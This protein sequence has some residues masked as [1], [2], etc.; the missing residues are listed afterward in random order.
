MA[1]GTFRLAND[2]NDPIY[3]GGYIV[4]SHNR[5]HLTTLPPWVVLHIPHDSTFIPASIRDQFTLSDTE[6][7]DEILKIHSLWWR[8]CIDLCIASGLCQFGVL[9]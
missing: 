5:P 9:F 6:L 7:D 1:K 8:H 2:P 3:T 4:S